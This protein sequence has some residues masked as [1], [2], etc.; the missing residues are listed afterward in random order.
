ML[1]A[2][3]GVA[4]RSRVSPWP[5]VG[6]SGARGWAQLYRWYRDAR[7]LF[8]TVRSVPE[9]APSEMVQRV[10]WSLV[11]MSP[12]GRVATSDVARVFAGAAMIH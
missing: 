11:A 3:S 4:V 10:L 7:Q 5:I 1:E 2:L 12:A 9:G 8:R 6:R